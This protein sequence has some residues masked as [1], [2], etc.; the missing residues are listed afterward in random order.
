[1]ALQSRN[2]KLQ[3]VREGSYKALSSSKSVDAALQKQME[4]VHAVSAIIHRACGEFPQHQGALRRLSLALAART[5]PESRIRPES[6][7]KK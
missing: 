2:K 7:A 4:R 3:G 1:M 5:Q 6:E